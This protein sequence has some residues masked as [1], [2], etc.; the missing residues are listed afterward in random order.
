VRPRGFA[1]FSDA[2]VA[3]LDEVVNRP[4]YEIAPRGM[5]S[6]ECLDVSF[7]LD[8]P[9]RRLPYLPG[10]KVN[11]VFHLAETLWYLSGRR[12]LAMP[13]YYAPRM[14]AYSV[15]GKT[16]AGTAYGPSLR[17]QWDQVV[18]LLRRDPDTKRAVI[19]LFRPAEL[20]V[21]DNPDVSC[22]IAV[23]FLLRDGRLNMTVYMRGNDAYRGMVGDVF[24]F[25]F[26]QE[27]VATQHGAALGSYAHH[28][29]SM[30]VNLPDLSAAKR[31]IGDRPR[32]VAMPPMPLDTT[33]ADVQAVC[34]Q[35]E[36]L[37]TGAARHTVATIDALKLSSY[38]RQVVLVFEVYRRIK[39]ETDRPVDART[40]ARLDP[41]YR[42][43]IAGRWP[44]RMA[45]VP[46]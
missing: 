17:T 11:V 41:A 43:P 24:A 34:E 46:A 4:E 5:P 40:I 38:W 3:V 16:M 15:D 44:D 28:V 7:R 37:R 8:D 39:Y 6:L 36:A 18:G 26:I 31:A 32:N 19:S 27:F 42:W 21:T 33:W 25:T 35:E 12:D 9:R 13:A 20:A 14:A 2:Y 45:E 30:H 1:G 23:Q 22:A 29:G 10:R